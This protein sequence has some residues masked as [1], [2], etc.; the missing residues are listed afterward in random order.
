MKYTAKEVLSVL[1]ACCDKFT[2]PMLDNG[3]VYLGA[4]RLSVFRSEENWAIT[5]EVFGFSP[6]SGIPD[7]HIYTFAGKLWNLKRPENYVSRQAYENYLANNPNNESRFIFPVEE[8][9][10]ID[11]EDVAANSSVVMVRGE[12]VPLP[13]PGDFKKFGIELEDEPEMRIY[14]L[15]RFL[16]EIRR[17]A[18]LAT[19]DELRGNIDPQMQQILRLDEWNHPDVVNN[20]CRPSKSETFQQLAEVIV[21]GDVRK[22]QPTLQPNTHWH[23][24]PDGGTL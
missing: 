20:D 16:T 19:P 15:C 9:D 12:S 23:N 7:T 1:D 22:Y 8:G 14:E 2:F 24:W 11:G 18:L 13:T 4:T 21:S 17:E 3:Y 10:W 6:R 5:I